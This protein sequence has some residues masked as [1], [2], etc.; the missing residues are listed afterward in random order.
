[1]RNLVLPVSGPVFAHWLKYVCQLELLFFS[2]A[3][4]SMGCLSVWM[5]LG[6]TNWQLHIDTPAF[7]STGTRIYMYV[8]IYMYISIITF[9]TREYVTTVQHLTQTNQH[10]AAVAHHLMGWVTV[11]FRDLNE[12]RLDAV[13][14]KGNRVSSR[15]R[16]SRC[17][18]VGKFQ[19]SRRLH[20]SVHTHPTGGFL[21]HW[22]T[23][24]WVQRMD[25]R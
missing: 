4:A 1:M 15:T 24:V 2:A 7:V 8:Y 23:R 14:Q 18:R 6:K 22:M 21:S 9:N 19:M 13:R 11:Y 25:I 20:T 17:S 10:R 16:C 12:Q 3:Y 5:E